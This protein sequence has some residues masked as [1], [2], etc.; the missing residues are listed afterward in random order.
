MEDAFKA[1]V[2]VAALRRQDAVGAR[3]ERARETNAR[4]EEVHGRARKRARMQAETIAAR[5]EAR[6]RDAAAA[7][8]ARR[9]QTRPGTRG[10]A[11]EA[12]RARWR[13]QPASLA[14]RGGDA[15]RSKKG[16]RG[17][18]GRRR[19]EQEGDEQAGADDRARRN[20]SPADVWD[21]E[22]KAVIDDGTG[23]FG[24]DG[25]AGSSAVR[26][27]PPGGDGGRGRS[28]VWVPSV[29]RA[30]PPGRQERDARRTTPGWKEEDKAMRRRLQHLDKVTARLEDAGAG[31]EAKLEI[32]ASE[33][34]RPAVYN[35]GRPTPDARGSADARG[36]EQLGFGTEGGGNARARKAKD[37]RPQRHADNPYEQ[38]PTFTAR[39]RRRVQVSRGVGRL[40]APTVSS[41]AKQTASGTAN[42][43]EAS[44]SPG[45]LRR[46]RPAIVTAGAVG[47]DY[48]A[49]RG[50][51]ERAVG[52][53]SG[54][55]RKERLTRVKKGAI[56]RANGRGG[57][58]RSRVVAA[59]KAVA[60]DTEERSWVGPVVDSPEADR[61]PSRRRNG[62]GRHGGHAGVK[63]ADRRVE[64]WRGGGHEAEEKG[65]EEEEEM[66]AQTTRVRRREGQRATAA[67][68][69]VRE[70]ADEYWRVGDADGDRW[71]DG[72][73]ERRRRDR[74][75]YGD[76]IAEGDRESVA[77]K[78]DRKQEQ[79]LRFSRCRVV[80]DG[81][82][83]I[84]TF[85][86]G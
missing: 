55:G 59:D 33:A 34:S 71:D 76:A 47:G 69:D 15:E 23:V 25:G 14:K 30:A 39:G 67:K 36:R 86:R 63:D 74:D 20:L 43:G 5:L 4:A 31:I 8:G 58:T 83:T 61:F 64:S 35:S 40:A 85:N 57:R 7:A 38:R 51:R 49:E 46:G 65:E 84:W 12:E 66:E 72:E 32:L 2:G 16:R 50:S 13:G 73:R 53:H 24:G 41:R 28:E 17:P 82:K 11:T 56:A 3:R 21:D 44:K 22:A 62:D 45:K 19:R 78:Q 52:R 42:V 77:I 18:G 9:R 68:G 48:V 1:L 70:R 75:A 79:D 10:S 81:V 29:V 80:G 27:P 26:G 54:T 60:V 6:A 37:E